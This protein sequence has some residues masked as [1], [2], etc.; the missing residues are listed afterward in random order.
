MPTTSAPPSLR[1]LSALLSGF[2]PAS[3]VIMW[4]SH[5]TCSGARAAEGVFKH[6]WAMMNHAHGKVL[7]SSWLLPT[8]KSRHRSRI[9][10][11]TKSGVCPEPMPAL[12]RKKPKQPPIPSGPTSILLNTPY[13]YSGVFF[14][15]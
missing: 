1:G 6:L 12:K 10:A 9:S 2:L 4:K 3:L 11:S 13:L 7:G 5:S 8:R 15:P 14:I